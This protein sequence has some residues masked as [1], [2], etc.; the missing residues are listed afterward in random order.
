MKVFS[1]RLESHSQE[2]ID[3]MKQKV[4]AYLEG[5]GQQAA[6]AAANIPNFPV[7]TGRMKNSINWAVAHN[8]GDGDTPNVLP[9]ECSVYIGT[10]VEYAPY[11]E[12]GTSRGIVARHFIQYGASSTWS[13]SKLKSEL[14]DYLKNG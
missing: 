5:I 6:S 3:E 13:S 10:N 11:H 1:V 7:D 4:N 8:Y 9:E 2:F 14:E 12:L